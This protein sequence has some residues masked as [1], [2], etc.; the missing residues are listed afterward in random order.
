MSFEA[1]DTIWQSKAKGAALLIGLGIAKH[2]DADGRAYP[3]VSRLA[4]MARITD[5]HARKAINELL[6][7]QVMEIYRQAGPKGTNVY[8]IRIELLASAFGPGG[9]PVPQDRRS[10]RTEA[11]AKGRS[12]RTAPPVPQDRTPCP[13][14]PHPPVSQDSRIPIESPENPHEPPGAQDLATPHGR[15]KEKPVPMP[16]EVRER[17]KG[18]RIGQSVIEIAERQIGKAP[19]EVQTSAPGNP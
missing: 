16:D 11:A 8:R 10:P 5:R 12:S 14:G 7:L 2:A 6:R 17:L 4:K 15:K 3:S 1:Y 19:A 18:S 9:Q 13:P